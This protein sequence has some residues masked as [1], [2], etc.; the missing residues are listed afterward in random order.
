MFQLTFRGS[1]FEEE[2]IR[3]GMIE[4]CGLHAAGQWFYTTGTVV[5]R[6]YETSDTKVTF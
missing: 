2:S 6:S 5:H 1:S 3:F 4:V